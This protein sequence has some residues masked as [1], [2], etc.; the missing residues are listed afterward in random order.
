MMF[1]HIQYIIMF[2]VLIIIGCIATTWRRL[3]E[4]LFVASVR[5]G[6]GV[7][8]RVKLGLNILILCTT[9]IPVMRTNE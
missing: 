6:V 5:V 8:V 4:Q 3:E 2:N 1:I 7:R 9:P